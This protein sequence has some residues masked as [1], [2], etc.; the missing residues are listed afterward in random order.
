MKQQRRFSNKRVLVTGG[1]SGIG[2][3]LT[4]QL[5]AQGARVVTTAR[6]EERLSTLRLPG[7]L[8]NQSACYF[9]KA[10]D[11]TNPDFRDKLIPYA[12]DQL[13][14]LDLVIT[15]AGCGA[16]GSLETM[17][18]NTFRSIVNLDLLSCAELVHASLPHLKN[19][20]DP[21]IV[22]IGSILGYCPLPLH[23]AY[24]AAKAGIISLAGSLRHELKEQGIDVLL[25]TLGPT[26]TE[27]WDALE[28]GE[29]PAWS[30]GKPLSSEATCQIILKALEHR[31]HEVIP[32]WRAKAF[33]LAARH[34]PWLMRFILSRLT[35]SAPKTFLK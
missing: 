8:N 19:G 9:Y 34:T 17:P 2:R 30:K 33:V 13:G 12:I 35:T 28:M 3:S 5:L 7:H 21:A 25:A 6:R 11:I 31:R 15:A 18:A 20:N 26:E 23:S 14:G 1:S 24:C 16:I 4:L 10:G 29:R 22:L 32:G 27:F